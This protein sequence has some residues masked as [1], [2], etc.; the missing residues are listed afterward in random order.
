MF[1]RRIGNEKLLYD[2]YMCCEMIEVCLMVDWL[3]LVVI[4][5]ENGEVVNF[6]VLVDSFMFVG[7]DFNKGIC[8]V[9]DVDLVFNLVEFMKGVC[10]VYEMIV[11]VFVEGDCNLFKNFFF[12]EVYEGF[13]VV[14]KDCEM[15]GEWMNLIFVGISKV[16]MLNVVVK[17]SE[18]FV[19]VC[20][21]S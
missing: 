18:V 20:I 1:G 10:V 5:C 14:I 4:G 2:F 15:K 9:I 19:M 3:V 16:D 17:G 7:S 12:C 8:V 11:M 13:E 21:V 6:Y